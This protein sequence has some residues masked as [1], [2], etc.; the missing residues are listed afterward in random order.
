MLCKSKDISCFD[1]VINMKKKALIVFSFFLY[2]W[3]MF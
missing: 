2:I 1:F 3:N